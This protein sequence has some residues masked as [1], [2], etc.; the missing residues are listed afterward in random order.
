MT[1]EPTLRDLHPKEWLTRRDLMAKAREHRKAAKVATQRG[2]MGAAESYARDA[3][4]LCLEARSLAFSC[5]ER[6]KV[7]E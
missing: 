4:A 2:M 6:A 7:A 3:A 1:T 5:A